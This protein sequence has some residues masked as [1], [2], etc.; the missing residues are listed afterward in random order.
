M[1]GNFDLA[2]LEA[3]LR[4]LVPAEYLEVLD[5]IEPTSMG[6]AGL[7]YRPDGSVA[8][9]EIW[10]SFCDLA[11]AGGPPH[12][13]TLLEPGTAGE[14]AERPEQYRAALREVCRGINMVTDLLAEPADPGW[15]RMH[16]ADEAMARWLVRA[17]TMETVS[18]R[19]DGM[20]L[21]LPIGPDYRLEKEIKN[22]VTVIAK[23]CHYWEGHMPRS[24][25]REIG[26]LLAAMERERPLLRP[27]P[28]IG[29]YPETSDRIAREGFAER[30]R[31]H[32]GLTVSPQRYSGWQ[33][34]ESANDRAALWTMRMLVAANV[35][36]RRE[37]RVLFVPVNPAQDAE[38]RITAELV[39]RIVALAPDRAPKS[40]PAAS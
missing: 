30:V 37:G 25:R 12:K 17:I 38:G 7:K 8:W 13:G 29:S 31:L 18:V 33:G 4:M 5:K 24:Q 15:V 22:V 11:M 39:S 9:D 6:S 40:S 14:I 20:V 19:Q 36:A 3:R 32:A 23:T 26:D 16:C 21:D 34:V 28:A 35:L 1:T 27:A 10:G 2:T